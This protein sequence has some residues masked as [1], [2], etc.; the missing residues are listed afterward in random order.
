VLAE[1]AELDFNGTFQNPTVSI[2][3]I[4]EKILTK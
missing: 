3:I 1:R 2:E 4:P